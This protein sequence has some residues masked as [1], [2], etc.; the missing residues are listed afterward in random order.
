MAALRVYC[1]EHLDC[2]QFLPVRAVRCN[3]QK[4]RLGEQLGHACSGPLVFFFKSISE[5]S[6]IIRISNSPLMVVASRGTRF[7]RAISLGFSALYC[8]GPAFPRQT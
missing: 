1:A 2:V 7:P 4:L 5:S 3:T 8:V 6:T